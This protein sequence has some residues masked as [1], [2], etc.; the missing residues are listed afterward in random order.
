VKDVYGRGKIKYWRWVDGR[1]GSGYKIFYLWN[2]LFDLVLIRYKKGSYIRWH[3]DPVPEGLEHHRI[4]VEVRNANG[5]KLYLKYKEHPHYKRWGRIVKFRPD[6]QMHKVSKI[7]SGER[8][9]L[10]LGWTKKESANV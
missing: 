2:W 7:L 5:G 6:I 4:N 10:S 3:V 9:V 1:Q 8:W